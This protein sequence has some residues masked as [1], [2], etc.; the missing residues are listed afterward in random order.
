MVN[1]SFS[2]TALSKN[3]G[4]FIVIVYLAD[5][6]NT[7]VSTE[8]PSINFSWWIHLKLS[9]NLFV[10]SKVDRFHYPSIE[11]TQVCN[12]LA[13]VTSDSHSK[14]GV[15]RKYVKYV[16]A[17]LKPVATR[18]MEVYLC[19]CGDM[20]RAT[21]VTQ[22]RTK[23]LGTCTVCVYFCSRVETCGTSGPYP[24]NGMVLRTKRFQ[25]QNW[26]RIRFENRFKN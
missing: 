5:P 19:L 14:V 16:V 3:R 9:S 7:W 23:H 10:Y 11:F 1:T 4:M 15:V 18:M 25:K 20:N 26:F 6:A 21:G 22:L 8:Y 17:G 2:Y 24:Q 13:S 12:E